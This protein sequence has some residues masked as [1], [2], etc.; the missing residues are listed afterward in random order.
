VLLILLRLT[1]YTSFKAATRQ[2]RRVDERSKL[3]WR[4][5]EQKE[6]EEGEE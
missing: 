1:L 6:G 4:R 5:E 2:G 3:K